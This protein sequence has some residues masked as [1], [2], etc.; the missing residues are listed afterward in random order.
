MKFQV[1]LACLLFAFIT[2][3]NYAVLVAGSN[4]YS[5]Y[6]HQS[7]IFHHYHIL[8]DRGIK[9]ENI[10]VFAYDDIADNS[11]NPF[12]GQVFNHPDGKDVY[13]GV[14]IDY[15]GKDVTP[16]NFIAAITGDADSVTKKD[17]RTTGKVLTSTAN[18]NVFMYFS[19]HG[20]DNIIA[21]PSKYLYADELNDALNVMH[22]KHMYKEL[23]FYLEACHSGSM[24]NK[25][26]PNNI[27]IYTTTAANP[28][29]SSYAEYCSYEAKVNGTLI[30]SCLGDEYS[31]RFMED[32]DS[33]PGAELKGYTLQEQYEY[34]VNAVKGS[35]VMQYGDL[36]IA[37]KDVADF[38]SK[39]GSKVYKWIKKGLNKILPPK[40]NAPTSIKIN[41]EN[42]RLEW[43][44]M[45][46]EQSNDLEAENEYYEEI[47]AQGR[48]TKI[49]E[50]FNKRFELGKIDYSAKVD[51][52]CYRQVSQSY[53]DRCGT[54]IDRD[55]KFMPNIANFCTKGINPKRAI[56]AF[57]TLCE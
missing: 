13:A 18:D 11:K 39:A 55:F 25:L 50:I 8:V 17:E 33:R 44:R 53:A 34:L 3:D 52:D 57:E 2:C 6:R 51:Y 32:I 43:Y 24:F 21:F 22:E 1:L 23:V 37:K 30:G 41:N 4:T 7:D 40:L 14:V 15:F 38:V 10:I 27:S 31:V 46:A 16:E 19:D 20:D 47:L 29:E 35:H 9:P 56:R 49:F 26:L 5:N 45:Q 28:D 36:S 12:P 54:L 42:Y 48:V